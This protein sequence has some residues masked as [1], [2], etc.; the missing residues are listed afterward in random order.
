MMNNDYTP[1]LRDDLGANYKKEETEFVLWAPV[2]EKV[3]LNLE[4]NDNTFKKYP[5]NKEDNGV[6]RLIVKGD[7]LNKKYFY[8]LGS[9]L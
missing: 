7:L 2:S 6:F 5:L 9:I 3:T 4:Q 1:Y 8:F